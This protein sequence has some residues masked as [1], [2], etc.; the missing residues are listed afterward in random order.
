MMPAAHDEAPLYL[1]CVSRT[2]ASA[3]GL[4]FHTP[5]ER[6]LVFRTHP[7]TARTANAVGTVGIELHERTSVDD[8][9]YF[10]GRST[11][12]KGVETLAAG[13]RAAKG[14]HGSLRLVVTGPA[15]DDPRLRTL[16][17]VEC[18]G[19]VGD[20]ERVQLVG[21]ALAS[22]VPGALESLSMLALETWATHRPCIV[23]GR[24]PTLAGQAQRSG[25][26]LTFTDADSLSEA[27]THLYEDRAEASRLGD[28][29]FAYV[30]DNYRWDAVCARVED[31]LER[32]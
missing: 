16:D 30:R 12:G 2:F 21:H 3:D 1:Q 13:F 18:K 23:N 25:G 10:G 32:L 7:G 8:Y 6:D 5:E 28:S 29:G 26:A 15:S 31:L 22:V 14:R 9:I 11:A 24:S 4:L 19:T 27:I 17:G 20:A